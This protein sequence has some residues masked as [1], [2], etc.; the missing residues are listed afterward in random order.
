MLA[1]NASLFGT[2]SALLSFVRHEPIT[3]RLM[4][5]NQVN[6]MVEALLLLSGTIVAMTAL[7]AAVR[8]RP[9]TSPF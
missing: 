2:A 7:A 6:G 3:E 5:G 8:R 4:K 1:T 9:S